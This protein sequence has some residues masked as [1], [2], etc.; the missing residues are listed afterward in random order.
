[1]NQDINQFKFAK[2]NAADINNKRNLCNFVDI[3]FLKQFINEKII[4]SRGNNTCKVEI[5]LPIN[6]GK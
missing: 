6:S 1:M 5:I 2:N 4:A 3:L